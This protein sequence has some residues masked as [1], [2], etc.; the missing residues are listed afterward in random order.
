MTDGATVPVYNWDTIPS[1]GRAPNSLRVFRSSNVLVA[2]SD[3]HPGGE[4]PRPHSHTFEE[5]LM[6]LEGTV[7]LHLGETIRD[8]PAGSVVRI[9]PGVVH[10]IDAPEAE[11]IRLFSMFSPPRAD[12]VALTGY[13]RD[14]F[15]QEAGLVAV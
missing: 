3:I 14:V 13:Q 5:V 1:Y 7:R 10:S 15:M 4:V 9:P 2:L 8:C 6:V 11:P 12:L